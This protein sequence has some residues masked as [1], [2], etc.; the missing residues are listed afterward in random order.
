MFVVKKMKTWLLCFLTV[1]LVWQTAVPVSAWDLDDGNQEIE[2]GEDKEWN[3]HD[4]HDGK[5]GYR[6]LAVAHDRI[7]SDT[8]AAGSQQREPDRKC[9]KGCACES[10]DLV[11]P[12]YVLY[13]RLSV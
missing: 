4:Y 3:D 11:K 13:R 6:E 12:P 1:L 5:N 10:G 7:L 8:G 9:R 2:N